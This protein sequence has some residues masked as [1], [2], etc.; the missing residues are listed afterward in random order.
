MKQNGCCRADKPCMTHTKGERKKNFP[1][2]LSSSP[3]IL[4]SFFF[5]HFLSSL[6]VRFHFY[7]PPSKNVEWEKR[8]RVNKQSKRERARKRKKKMLSKWGTKS[9]EEEELLTALC[10]THI[11]GGGKQ[12]K[13]VIYEGA[14][15]LCDIKAI[16]D[17]DVLHYRY[18]LRLLFCLVCVY[19]CEW[20]PIEVK[21]IKEA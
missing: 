19:V 9:E 12:L 18:S 17:F 7:H 10:L 3:F 11:R 14:K 6:T 1:F 16:N 8:K 21:M 15:E 2:I 5:F 20:L 4:F 13:A